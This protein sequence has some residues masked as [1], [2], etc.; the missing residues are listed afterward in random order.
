MELIDE[1]VD[2]SCTLSSVLQHIHVGLLYV[3]RRS[4]DRP[5]MLFV[6]QMLTSESLLLKPKQPGFFTDSTK[7]DFSSKH[8]TCSVNGI[9]NTMFEAQ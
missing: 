8:G 9:T 3:Q 5:N 1:L 4:E 7:E 2:N 6:V